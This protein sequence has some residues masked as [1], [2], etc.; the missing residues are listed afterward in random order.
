MATYTSSGA[1]IAP[2]SFIRVDFLVT[3]VPSAKYLKLLSQPTR[4][5]E[6]SQENF[7]D[8]DEIWCLKFLWKTVQPF[9]LLFR[10]HDFN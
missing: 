2:F 4:M 1:T 8:F 10:L 5:H 9:Q 7:T 3:F 6:T